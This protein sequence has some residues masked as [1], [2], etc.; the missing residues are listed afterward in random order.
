MASGTGQSGPDLLDE[1]DGPG[2]WRERVRRVAPGLPALLGYRRGDFSHDLTAGL[3][4]AAVALPVGVAYA[5]LAGF[6]PVAGLYA[7]ILP[8][9]AYAVFGTSRQLIVGPDS[10]TCALIAAAIAPLAGGDASLYLSLSLTLTFLT[11]LFCIG[12]SFLRLGALADFLSKPILVGFLNGVALSIVL[13]Q[14]GKLFGFTIERGHILPRL[15]EFVGK[16]GQTHAPTLAISALSFAV[17]AIG[18]RFVRRL[19]AAL[20][21]M[22]LAGTVTAAFDLEALG[23]A[24]IG[25]VP[26]G[27]PPLHIPHFPIEMLPTLLADA[28]GLAL[29]SFSS[30][31]LTA[32]GFAEKNGYEIDVDREFSALGAANIAAALSQGFAVS[33]ADSRTAMA[34]ASGGRTQMTGIVA[35]SAIALVLLFFTSPLSYVPVAALGA[36]LVYGAYSLVNVTI[37]KRFYRL[38]RYEFALSILATLGVATIG[39]VQAILFVVILALLRFVQLTSRP[40]IHVLGEVDGLP[41]LH[42]LDHHAD[43]RA[44]PGLVLLR[45]N[46]PVVF[47]NAPYFRRQVMAAVERA[48][49]ELRWFVLDMLPITGVDATGFF[50]MSD[51]SARLRA[52]GVTV[53]LAGRQTE[54]ETWA[55]RTGV[56]DDDE[57]RH[58]LRYPTLRQAMRAYALRHSGQAA[59]AR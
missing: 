54:Y 12:A 26:A 42:A 44:M 28:A 25:K 59:G 11:G 39:A 16:L 43:A 38:S 55:E 49:P 18:P 46:G 5:Q 7:S 20:L 50:V 2:G 8:L 10:A 31:M 56:R 1:G 4:V 37:L 21:A 15:F 58:I 32:R 53:V 14:L 19:P 34:D 17:L 13:G 22:L 23:V 9:L 33:G 45:F 27:L 47:F 36:V 51:V 52:R 35:A 29:V 30:M 3:S 48:G 6:S 57:A 41:G 24:T 40:T